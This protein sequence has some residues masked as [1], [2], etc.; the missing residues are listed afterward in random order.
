DGYGLQLKVA[1]YAVRWCTFLVWGS[2][3]AST[4][5]LC[6]SLGSLTSTFGTSPSRAIARRDPSG[7][8]STTRK[9]SLR[10]SLP[11]T[12]LPS[13]IVTVTGLPAPP[14]PRPPNGL[15]ALDPATHAFCSIR[16]SEYWVAKPFRS[17]ATE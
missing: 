8:V 13:F 9:S 2:S 15:L 10:T 11:S 6:A 14:P 1:R 17:P 7:S 5:F 3:M 12:L 4:I 16:G